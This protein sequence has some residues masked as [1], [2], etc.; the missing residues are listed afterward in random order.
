[1][2][3]PLPLFC[4]VGLAHYADGTKEERKDATIVAA[5][6][7]QQMQGDNFGGHRDSMPRGARSVGL[8]IA[9]P[10][11]QHVYGIPEHAT[12]L[13]LPTTAPGT[14]DS[15]PHYS[16]PYRL[17]NLDV[18]E[19]EIGNTMALY[20]NIPLLVAHGK[21]GQKSMTAVSFQ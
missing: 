6:E 2:T 9:F 5:G 15:Q 7:Q 21:A 14:A 3:V 10:Y 4:T 1:V 11:A 13:A 20:G 16:E 17:Y 8:D 12:S 18:F 19:Y